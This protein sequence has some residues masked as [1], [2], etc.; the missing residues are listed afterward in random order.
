MDRGAWQ[1]IVHRVS[2][3]QTYLRDLTH[4][5]VQFSSVTQLCLTLCISID[6]SVQALPDHYQLP[7][8][9]QTHVH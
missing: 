8:F 9:T 2:K 7:E 5:T 6:W 3:S 1:S 4:L